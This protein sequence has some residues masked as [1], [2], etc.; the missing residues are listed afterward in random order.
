MEAVRYARIRSIGGIYGRHDRQNEIL[1][2][3]RNRILDPSIVSAIPD[4]IESFYGSVRTD[5]S[6]E[7]LYHLFCL[8]INLSMDDISFVGMPPELFTEGRNFRGDSVLYTDHTVIRDLVA[9]FLLG[10]QIL[11]HE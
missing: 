2:Q 11:I 7:Q 5:L 3:L 9:D 6:L 10:D 8:S 4:L 1:V